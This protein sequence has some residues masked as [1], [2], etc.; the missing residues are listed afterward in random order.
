MTTR[1]GRRDLVAVRLESVV[2]DAVRQVG[3]PGDS[4]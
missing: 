1:A 2:K 4:I 3:L